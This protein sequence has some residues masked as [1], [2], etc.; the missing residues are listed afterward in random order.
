MPSPL[1]SAI[2]TMPLTFRKPL[3][4]PCTL[5]LV[6]VSSLCQPCQP[7]RALGSQ[8]PVGLEVTH[9]Q[10]PEGGAKGKGEGRLSVKKILPHEEPVTTRIL[11]LAPPELGLGVG[12]MTSRA[13]PLQ[14]RG[15]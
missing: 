4:L 1:L 10:L 6:L 14:M 2:Q 15:F 11:P 3:R 12:G 7:L 5:V 9:V 13:L 8:W